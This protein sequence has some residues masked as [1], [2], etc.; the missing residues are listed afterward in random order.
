VL[1]ARAEEG[2]KLS[3]GEFARAAKLATGTL[4]GN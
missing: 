1:R 4:L 2:K 3:G